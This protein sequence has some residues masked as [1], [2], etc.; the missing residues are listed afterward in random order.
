MFR[1]VRSHYAPFESRRAGFIEMSCY[2]CLNIS[3]MNFAC[4]WEYTFYL[5]NGNRLLQNRFKN[6]FFGMFHNVFF[7]RLSYIFSSILYNIRNKTF[8]IQFEVWTFFLSFDKRK[9]FKCQKYPS[10]NFL[11]QRIYLLFE[12]TTFH[13]LNHDMW[14]DM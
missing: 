6:I 1:G 13:Y 14:F 11:N 3:I 5:H 2:F 10:P 4:W 7:I 9:V 8:L 12:N